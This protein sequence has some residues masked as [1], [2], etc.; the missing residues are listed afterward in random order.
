M[1]EILVN[2]EFTG[3]LSPW[4]QEAGGGS[5]WSYDTNTA[6][7]TPYPTGADILK[8]TL[9]SS[10]ASGD[11][12]YEINFKATLF[13]FAGPG[14]YDSGNIL[15]NLYSGGVFTE[16]FTLSAF[17]T[18]NVNDSATGTLSATLPF[19]EVKIDLSYAFGSPGG[20]Y[21]LIIYD[22]S[23][24]TGDPTI[25]QRP[26]TF[27]PVYNPVVYKLNCPSFSE[28]LYRIDVD[29]HNS[30]DDSLIGSMTVSPNILGV[31]FVDVSFILKNVLYRDWELTN[32]SLIGS[33]GFYI[34]YQEFF[35]GSSSTI[36]DDVASPRYAVIAA[37]QIGNNADL[38]AYEIGSSTKKFLTKFDTPSMWRGYPFS[39]SFINNQPGYYS[40]IREYNSAGVLVYEYGEPLDLQT[41]VLTRYFIAE[42]DEDTKTILFNI[43][44]SSGLVLVTNSSTWTEPSPFSGG[45]NFGSKSG[46]LFIKNTMALATE[47]SAE[48][49]AAITSG[50]KPAK[51]N[52]T[53][54]VTVA[55][56]QTMT[57][58]FIYLTAAHGNTSSFVQKTYTTSGTNEEILDFPV[59]A[60]TAAYFA[61]IA[62]VTGSAGTANISI[63]LPKDQVMY[64]TTPDLKSETKT[65][66]VKDTCDNPIYL[67]WK[68]SL[69][70]DAFWM[71]DHSQDYSWIIEDNKKAN[72]QLLFAENITI[73]E[74]D[75]INEVNTVGV[76]YQPAIPELLSTIN[77]TSAR[78]DQQ[79]YVIDEDGNKTGVI[80]ITRNQTTRTRQAKHFVD[81]LIEYPE[82]FL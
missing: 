38:D 43:L 9:S 12:D 63:N 48:Q 35:T 81:V 62:F 27:S 25:T 4:T 32:A 44:G 6:K 37:L 61:V 16:Q 59:L 30:S 78:T 72:Q 46:N 49:A 34:K 42:T 33:I 54:I 53:I 69:G 26:Y 79:L 67:F 66:L 52:A 56:G 57:V 45:S 2:G 17:Q 36:I 68:N 47:Y 19:D 74:F 31:A 23:I 64:F 20:T 58:Q 70:G 41:E 77:K 71:F 15:I 65:I 29:V 14:T 11:Y 18:D 5:A 55:A 22:I 21:D 73:N 80:N 51:L 7:V 28:P 40:R 24:A 1:A 3:S 76:V 60:S 8:Q 13:E 10:K 50:L 82:L 75:A 39:L